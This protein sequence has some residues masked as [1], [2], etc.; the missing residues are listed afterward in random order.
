MADTALATTQKPSLSLI[1][2]SKYGIDQNKVYAILKETALKSKDPVSDAEVAAFM[3]VCNQFE[4][5]PFVKEIYGFI[6]KGKMQ[7]VISVDGWNTL[8]NRNPNMNGIEFEEHFKNNKI[9]AVTCRIH[10]KDRALPTVITEYF[11]KCQRETDT[12]K[13]WPVRML[14]HKALIQCARIAFG[15]AGA[16]DEDE[17]ERMTG[18]VAPSPGI[19]DATVSQERDVEVE[20]YMD[21]LE[22]PVAKRRALMSQFAKR[23]KLLEYLQTQAAKAGIKIGEKK[24]AEVVEEANSTQPELKLEPEPDPA[25]Q[26]TKPAAK[27]SNKPNW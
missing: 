13:S 14:R 16:M 3:V 15:L 2:S 11:S 8:I 26:T 10:R 7:Y 6:S 21:A 18:Y 17:A 12:W 1:F 20:S 24:A 22:Y 9:E 25:E 5:N 23:E 4:L 19:I 27:K